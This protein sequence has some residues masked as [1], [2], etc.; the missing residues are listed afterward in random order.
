MYCSYT[1]FVDGKYGKDA[2]AQVEVSC[3]PFATIIAAIKAV[4]AARLS[5][6]LEWWLI[7][8]SPGQYP[9]MELNNV[10]SIRFEG[11]G[12]ETTNLGKLTLI[13]CKP[14]PVFSALSIQGLPV[15][16]MASAT[17]TGLLGA[18]AF[19]SVN[20]ALTLIDSEVGF[21]NVSVVDLQQGSSPA[22]WAEDS[23]IDFSSG[24]VQ[25]RSDALVPTV[26]FRDTVEP[27]RSSYF[28]S[29]RFDIDS[30]VSSAVILNQSSSTTIVLENN[31]F[32]I[33]SNEGESSIFQTTGGALSEIIASNTLVTGG[34]AT[35][36]LLQALPGGLAITRNDGDGKVA[37]STTRFE[38][39]QAT[40]VSQH[41]GNGE[42][43]VQL[44]A[45]GTDI[46]PPTS[47][48][49]INENT[50]DRSKSLWMEGGLSLG[51]LITSQDAAIQDDHYLCYYEPVGN[52]I[53]VDLPKSADRIGR[54][55]V[56]SVGPVPGSEV[57][58]IY[59]A[60]GDTIRFGTVIYTNLNPLV[61]GYGPFQFPNVKMYAVQ[62]ST[63]SFWLATL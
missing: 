57:V 35:V 37:V 9:P 38:F 20:S 61:L 47:G 48:N 58:R 1:A 6:P 7:K 55:L 4:N 36:N 40:E 42:T 24:I 39:A 18:S 2:T 33:A 12:V 23:V 52:D 63:D 11:S 59:P 31:S 15:A 51:V 60:P 22:I 32:N 19:S 21:D 56:H 17:S 29:V 49:F 27:T 16:P 13:N 53:R 5:N 45:R 25:S 28:S 8:I 10:F 14:K 34:T 43:T 26:S 54:Q 44:T 62:T 41:T 3:R 46:A 30:M 50:N